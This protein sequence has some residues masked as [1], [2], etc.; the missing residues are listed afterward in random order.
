M[1][2]NI[3]QGI[4]DRVETAHGGAGSAL[5]YKFKTLGSYGGELEGDPKEIAKRFPCFLAMFAGIQS[6]E[7]LGPNTYKHTAGFALILGNQDRRNNESTRRGVGAKP[8]SYQLVIDIL[9]LISGETLGLEIEP[10][11]PG[12]VRALANSKSLSIYSAE[13]S[14]KFVI[15]YELADADLDDFATLNTDWDV[16][17]LGNVSTTLPADDAD[18]TDTIELETQ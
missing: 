9:K 13:V 15:E 16:P 7:E 11:V 17:T 1:I 6:T 14:T 2:G 10:I 5:G 3:E 4:I 8:G 18:A 12:R